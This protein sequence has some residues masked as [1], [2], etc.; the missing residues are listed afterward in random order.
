VSKT[1]A[2]KLLKTY[3]LA[4]SIIVFLSALLGASN[5]QQSD[6]IIQYKTKEFSNPDSRIPSMF[7]CSFA[8]THSGLAD[9]AIEH[10]LEAF[11]KMGVPPEQVALWADDAVLYIKYERGKFDTAYEWVNHCEEPFS[12]MRSIYKIE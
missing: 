3:I 6:E 7:V 10:L 8:G 4:L 1:G 9:D 5:A 12:K 11:E 2:D